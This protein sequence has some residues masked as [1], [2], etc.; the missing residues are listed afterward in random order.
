MTCKGYIT[1]VGQPWDWTVKNGVKQ[2]CVKLVMRIPCGT[3]EGN[4]YFDEIMGEVNIGNPEILDSLKRT[5][6]AGE[7]CEFE[8]IFSLVDWKGKIIQDIKVIRLAKPLI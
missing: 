8:L 1:E 7:M 5:C 3:R 2:Q 6:E 4:E